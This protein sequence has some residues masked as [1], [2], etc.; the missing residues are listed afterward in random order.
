MLNLFL[1]TLLSRLD[2]MQYSQIEEDKEKKMWQVGE[3]LW[4]MSGIIQPSFH[5]V[6]VL[7]NPQDG[8]GE[9]P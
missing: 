2:S 7:L 4:M 5:S 3:E 9:R 6:K 8:F 1:I